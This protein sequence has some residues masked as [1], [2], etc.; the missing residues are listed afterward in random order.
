[1]ETMLTE[2]AASLET[3]MQ[4]GV[5][6]A[7]ADDDAART[8]AALPYAWTLTVHS[9]STGDVFPVTLETDAL[10]LVQLAQQLSACRVA[11]NAVARD[12]LPVIV[13]AE[14]GSTRL[15]VDDMA[16][17][18][19]GDVVLLDECRIDAEGG[20]WLVTLDGQ[21]AGVRIDRAGRMV[22][23]DR[24]K[25]TDP[26]LNQ[27]LAWMQAAAGWSAAQPEEGLPVQPEEVLPAQPEE[28][29]PVPV[30]EGLPLHATSLGG[31]DAHTLDIN[32]IPVRLTF[33]LG[34]RSISVGD[35]SR[36]QCGEVFALDRPFASAVIVR[37]NGAVVGS[38]E[39]VDIDGRIGVVIKTLG[40][41][42]E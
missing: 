30:E 23:Q 21:H 28:G 18:R 8:A 25:M 4:T 3:S 2:V 41:Q 37:A 38:G 1:M 10:G 36:L 39:L 34:D 20:L 42:L 14:V 5:P 13:R 7:L 29:A 17:L 6:R 31:S 12:A 40:T 33:D 26:D 15:T 11:S 35:L 27:D 22:F 24:E 19:R 9:H 32:R 16:V